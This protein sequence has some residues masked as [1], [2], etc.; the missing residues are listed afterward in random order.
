MKRNNKLGWI[1]VNDKALLSEMK[2]VQFKLHGTMHFPVIT[3]WHASNEL[4]CFL[5]GTF[6]EGFFF[7]LEPCWMMMS[8]DIFLQL[9]KLYY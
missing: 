4:F 9:Y 3:L 2:K 8:P 5:G 6:W 1:H 7:K